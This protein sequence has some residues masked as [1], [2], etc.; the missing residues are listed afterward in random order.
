M[1]HPRVESAALLQ[2]HLSIWQPDLVSASPAP[3]CVTTS[4]HLQ[5]CYCWIQ[6]TAQSE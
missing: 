4:W 3:H 6:D 1:T 5:M 2:H